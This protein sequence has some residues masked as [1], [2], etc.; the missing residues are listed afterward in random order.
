MNS[1]RSR[2]PSSR[3]SRPTRPPPSS[4]RIVERPSKSGF[5][6]LEPA[7]CR[8]EWDIPRGTVE[9]LPDRSRIDTGSPL[10]A[11]ASPAV[12]PHQWSSSSCLSTGTVL[13]RVS[14]VQAPDVDKVRARRVEINDER[15]ERSPS[16]HWALALTDVFARAL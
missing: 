10:P 8:E 6:E 1:S 5:P 13:Y 2:T 4:N 15:Q 9:L 11:A 14:W 12:R 3:H 16:P 7:G